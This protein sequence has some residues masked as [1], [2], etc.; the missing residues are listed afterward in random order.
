[1]LD[2]QHRDVAGESS[3]CREQVRAFIARHTSRR[4]VEQ[5]NFRP[6]R[7]RQRDLQ[8]PLFPIGEF[9]RQLCAFSAQ[10]QGCEYGLRLV[11]HLREIRQFPPEIAGQPAPLAHGKCHR[12]QGIEM[13]KQRVDLKSADQAAPDTLVGL[14][15]R[16]VVAAQPDA[17]RVRPQ[18]A[19][20]EIDEG[21]LTGTVGPNEGVACALR[22]GDGD[23]FR[24]HEGPEALVESLR[25]Q[26]RCRCLRGGTLAHDDRARQELVK[27]ESPPS[28]PL[29][30]NITTAT[31]RSPIQKYQSCGFIPAT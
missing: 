16:N 22:K 31:S 28:T 23:A 19:R 25:R 27:R 30:R 8:Q 1:M 26:G 4:L 21:R 11:D 10:R 17:P 18:H 20:Y 13:R 29:G 2:E 14:Q 24:D 3:D 12:L 9:P 7:K 6:C 15:R 5:Q